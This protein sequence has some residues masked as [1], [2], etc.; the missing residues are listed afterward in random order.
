MLSRRLRVLWPAPSPAPSLLLRSL[1]STPPYSRA[2]AQ[3]T[4]RR[5]AEY[6]QYIS[7]YNY[8][9]L[10]ESE[11]RQLRRDLLHQ[12]G[13]LGV[14]GRVYV[15]RE[16]VNAQLVLP[17]GNVRALETSF[18]VLLTGAKLF[19][20]HLFD[21]CDDRSVSARELFHKLD[22]RVRDQ[23]VRDG[24]TRGALDLQQSG[25][26]LPPAEW[27]ARL[28]Q[29]NAAN[30]EATLVLDVRNF[31]EHEIGRFDGATRIMVDTFRDTFDAVDEILAAHEARHGGAKPREVMMYCTGGIRCEKVG[32][33]LTQYKGIENVQKLHGG[34]VNYM[35][36]LKE[37]E[38]DGAG[39][40]AGSAGDVDANSN[41]TN[42]SNAIATP[43]TGPVQSLFK[44]KNFVFDQR[45]VAGS[46]CGG[47]E[48][49]AEEVTPDVLGAC[50]QCGEPCNQ[51]TNCANLMCGGLILQ[52]ASCSSQYFS[53]CS[54]A[55]KDEVVK[56]R[57]M[58]PD[59]HRE[60]RK[61]NTP[62]WKPANPNAST[63][64]QKFIKFRPL[65]LSMRAHSFSSS[66]CVASPFVDDS[67]ANGS[68]VSGID[69][70]EPAQ[71]NEYVD[72]MSSDHEDEQLLAELRSATV[73]HWPKAVQLIEAPQGKLLRFLVETLQ[74]RRVLEIGCFTGYSALCMANGLPGDDVDATL[75]TCDVDAH[76]MAFARSYFDRS[77]RSNQIQSVVSDGMELLNSLSDASAQSKQFDLIFIDAN[78]KQY[79]AYYEAVLS[80]KLLSPRGLLVFD[81]TL[82]HGRVLASANGSASSKERLAHSLAQ[83]NAD[84]AAD[85]RTT[86]VLLPLWDGLTVVRQLV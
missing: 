31:Y 53:A 18:P 25:G 41:G 47:A 15:A 39:A 71:L 14:L 62:L 37:S 36:F 77:S 13:E 80:M 38:R 26:S 29:R 57:A 3:K 17:V 23:I 52:C 84:V 72:R 86:Q 10:V 76:T 68:S 20:G 8:T 59:E 12:W 7:L 22:V 82:F 11:L 74:A 45:C 61:Q 1:S 60:Y 6:H 16:G 30:D 35:R 64:Y 9:P 34:I 66:S 56:M 24:F 42:E 58:T 21:E 43:S 49:M 50:F 55:C 5:S 2:A 40:G 83:F 54:E 46:S 28:A 4:H 85:S 27:H 19:Y 79:R 65:P 70:N 32:A 51:H 67:T 78:K 63:S 33:Y 69:D 75:L 44:G 81:N 48:H 73:R